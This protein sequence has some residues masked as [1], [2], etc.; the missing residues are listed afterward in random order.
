MT[1][2][3]KDRNIAGGTTAEAGELLLDEDGERWRV[4]KR[5]AGW[6]TLERAED[7]ETWL[8]HEKAVQEAKE[9]EATRHLRDPRIA[10]IDR[11][12]WRYRREL[13]AFPLV[14]GSCCRDCVYGGDPRYVRLRDKVDRVEGWRGILAEKLRVRIEREKRI[15]ALDVKREPVIRRIY[16]SA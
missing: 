7:Y 4:L 12:L 15:D 9:R 13:E 16:D 10:S 3:I 5:D 6:L 1:L 14:V 2:Y 11:A 8:S